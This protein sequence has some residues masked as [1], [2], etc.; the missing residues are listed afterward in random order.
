MWGLCKMVIDSLECFE[1]IYFCFEI[2]FWENIWLFYYKVLCERN[3]VILNLV[4]YFILFLVKVLEKLL[5]IMLKFFF[6]DKINFI[7]LFFS[8]MFV[9]ESMEYFDIL[10][11][12]KEYYDYKKII[13]CNIYNIL[14][15]FKCIFKNC[16]RLKWYKFYYDLN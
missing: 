8:F 9:L 4:Y 6:I 10:I 13:V 14:L 1:D 2:F 5:V 11:C 12:L 16:I 15:F 7:S 3:K